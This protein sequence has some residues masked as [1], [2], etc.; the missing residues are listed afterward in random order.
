MARSDSVEEITPQAEDGTFRRYQGRMGVLVKA[1]GAGGCLLFILYNARILTYA[2]IYLQDFQYNAIFMGV[3]LALTFIYVPAHKAAPRNRLPWYDILLI[4]GGLAG[5]TYISVNA[6]ELVYF[7]K[8]TA[9]PFEMV[10]GFITILVLIEAVRRSFGWSVVIM[11]M[12]FLVYAKFGYLLNGPLKVAY[13][14]W[15]TLISDFYLSPQGIF[16]PLSTISSGI[17]ITFVTFG[18]IFTAAGGAKF[19]LNL[20]LATTGRMRGGPA[21]AAIVGSALFGTIS[22][23]ATANVVVTGSVT[24]P[25]MKAT[26]YKGY[27]AGAIETIASTGGTIM[28]PIMGGLAFIMAEMVGLPY[29]TIAR[30]AIIP[31]VLYFASLFMQVHFHAAK[32]GL[33]GLPKEEIPSL[34]ATIRENW[35]LVIPF[36]VLITLLFVLFLP[37]TLAGVYTLVTVVAISMFRKK[38]R[39]NLKKFIDSLER[40]MRLTL[41]IANIIALIGIILGV[42]VI[43]GLGPRISSALV[44]LFGNNIVL[45][46]MAT[47]L[48]CYIMGSGVSMMAVYI[49]VAS[50]V[51]PPLV[52]FGIPLIAVHFFIMFMVTSGYF[53]PPYCVAAYMAAPIADASAFRIGFQAM[54]LGIVTFLV[55]FIIVFNPAFIQIGTLVEIVTVTISALIGVFALSAGLEGY[56]FY[57]TNW[58][59][60]VLLLT[61]GIAMFIPGLV[62]DLAGFGI[63][64]LVIFW[65][66]RNSRKVEAAGTATRDFEKVQLT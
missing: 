17:I 58:P 41:P 22:G 34:K 28:P 50:L 20:A 57:K 8:V 48:V 6:L 15:P 46:V 30:M 31:A 53:T 42:M 55:P 60:R 14:P 33:R 32:H 27:Y 65:Q 38:H 44:T 59:H 11:V 36:V 1:L 40:G 37:A 45:L 66:W 56:L 39:I 13:T 26:G 10:L 12:F 63:I 29:S 54:R 7:G 43:T 4:L 23:Q 16:G 21:K 2:K 51:A 24:I 9:T 61:G 35:E 25:L 18:V 5:T 62:T 47:A 19:F 52:Q 49:V 3:V 64:A